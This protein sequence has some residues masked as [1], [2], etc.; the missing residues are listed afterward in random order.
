L[1]AER[2]LIDEKIKSVTDKGL[3]YGKGEL[4]SDIPHNGRISANVV[5]SPRQESL[6]A[7]TQRNIHSGANCCGVSEALISATAKAITIFWDVRRC[8]S[9]EVHQCFGRTYRFHLQG[10]RICQAINQETYR[11]LLAD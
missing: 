2:K 4:L 8:S 10:Q 3:K 6:R 1:C 7:M 9:L 11:V 5:T